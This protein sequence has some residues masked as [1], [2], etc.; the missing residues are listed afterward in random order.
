MTP[1]IGMAR[2]ICVEYSWVEWSNHVGL[3][4]PPRAK[5]IFIYF[6]VDAH[7]KQAPSP[8]L[9]FCKRVERIRWERPH[10]GWIKLNMD[11]LSLGNPGAAVVG[12]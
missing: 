5:F 2:S 4:M 6:T 12:V 3:L 10:E 8:I 11:G 1:R 7:E 9:P